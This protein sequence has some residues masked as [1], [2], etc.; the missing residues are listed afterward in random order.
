MYSCLYSRGI[1][2]EN[3]TLWQM[4]LV[5]LTEFSYAMNAVSGAQGIIRKHI[6]TTEKNFNFFFLVLFR[7]L[8]FVCQFCLCSK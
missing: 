8:C 1:Q 4:L 5:Q 7:Y 3:L 6:S 2:Y